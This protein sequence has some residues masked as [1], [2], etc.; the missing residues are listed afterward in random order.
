MLPTIPLIIQ[1]SGKSAYLTEKVSSIKK[2]PL[3][4][5]E[6]FLKSNFDQ[7]QTCKIAHG[8][9][10]YIWN[11]N[12]TR[13]LYIFITKKLSQNCTFKKAMPSFDQKYLN[14]PGQNISG[15]VKKSLS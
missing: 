15:A 13:F 2:L 10:H 6:S 12:A 14:N 7:N 1:I 5:V 8:Q 3:S 4:K 9:N 11:F